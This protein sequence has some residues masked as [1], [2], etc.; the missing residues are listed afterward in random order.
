MFSKHEHLKQTLHYH[1]HVHGSRNAFG[2]WVKELFLFVWHKEE[3][4][5]ATL[6]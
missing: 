3:C 5:R 4:V 6:N 2:N 1:A